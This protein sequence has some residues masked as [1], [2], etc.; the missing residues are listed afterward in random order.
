M[1]DTIS[2]DLTGQVQG[3]IHGDN[4]QTTMNR[5][6]TIEVL[7]MTHALRS[8]FDRGTGM[9]TGRRYYEPITFTKRIDRSSPLLRKALTTNEI[10]SGSFKWFR[11]NPDGS[12]STEQFF[13]IAF[14]NGRVV[15]AEARLPNT[16]DTDSANLPP[17]E[18]IKLVFNTISWKFENGGIEH[19]DTWTAV[20]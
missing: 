4:S 5:A 17:I 19:Q 8:A 10:V 11:P 7:S 15:S 12:G 13:T 9:A 18:E 6:N 1:A 14:T 3:A 20:A 2:L 16:L